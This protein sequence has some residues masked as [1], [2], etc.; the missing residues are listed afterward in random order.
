MHDL[1]AAGFATHPKVG[2]MLAGAVRSG[3]VAHA[4]LFIGPTGVGK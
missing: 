3:K 2:R 4:Y 1:V